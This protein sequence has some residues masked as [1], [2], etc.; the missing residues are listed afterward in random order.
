MSSKKAKKA[1]KRQEAIDALI[2]N[3][4]LEAAAKALG[5]SID[6][7][8]LQL[9]DSDFAADYH[10]HRRGAYDH[11]MSRLLATASQ[12][13]EVLREIMLDTSITASSRVSAATNTINL[14]LKFADLDLLVKRVEALEATLRIHQKEQQP[15][16]GE[17]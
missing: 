6:R 15:A 8:L 7:L 12:G 11:A 16:D 10:R 2:Q 13:I 9:E 3:P 1:P 4:S 5:W 14:G 17:T